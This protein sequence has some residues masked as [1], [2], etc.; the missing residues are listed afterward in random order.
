MFVKDY[1]LSVESSRGIPGGYAVLSEQGAIDQ[2]ACLPAFCSTDEQT[3]SS[4]NRDSEG[5]ERF[6]PIAEESR[7]RPTLAQIPMTSHATD[8]IGCRDDVTSDGDSCDG[9][10]KTMMTEG[11]ICNS[12]PETPASRVTM[13][14]GSNTV[15]IEMEEQEENTNSGDYSTGVLER[16]RPVALDTAALDSGS[17]QA[18]GTSAGE[19]D[20]ELGGSTDESATYAKAKESDSTERMESRQ[21]DNRMESSLEE[22]QMESSLEEDRLLSSLEKEDRTKT[23]AATPAEQEDLN[24]LG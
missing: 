3:P 2:E 12:V 18:T 16:N 6:L 9:Y 19:E 20:D 8:V 17:Y 1:L 15:A 4:D 24:N 10:S 23:H 14:T 21:E 11:N 7:P 5:N 22:M 13:A